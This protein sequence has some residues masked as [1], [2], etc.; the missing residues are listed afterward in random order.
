[1]FQSYKFF[2]SCPHPG[3]ER[4]RPT[5][6]KLE[7]RNQEN[8][9]EDGTYVNQQLSTDKNGI[10]VW[11]N[12]FTW[13]WNESRSRFTPFQWIFHIPSIPTIHPH[14]AKKI[15]RPHPIAAI[16]ISIISYGKI[17]PYGPAYNLVQ[18]LDSWNV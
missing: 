12:A 8:F 7:R 16:D 1:M 9:G 10:G 2:P 18:Q 17:T 13:M 11:S 4:T 3:Y 6:N 5:K 14:H 15:S